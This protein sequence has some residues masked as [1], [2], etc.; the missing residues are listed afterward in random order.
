MLSLSLTL[1]LGSSSSAIS[2]TIIRLNEKNTVLLMG[3]V[4]KYSVMLVNSELRKL[5]KSLPSKEPIY[6]ILATPGGSVID[7]MDIVNLAQS[8]DRPVHT[9]TSFAASMGFVIAQHLNKRYILQNGILMSHRM[10]ASAQGEVGGE[11]DEELAF[12]KAISR[13]ISK[14][15]AERM[16]MELEAYEKRVSDEWWLYG[17]HA[18]E[19]K[20]ADEVVT[21][22]CSEGLVSKGMCPIP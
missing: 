7:G 16:S 4:D 2:R 10:K 17:Q 1:L 18:V 13:E 19:N 12:A 21:V 15:C 8:L 9:I 5:N 20:A 11:M 22:D 6:L 14:V 3:P